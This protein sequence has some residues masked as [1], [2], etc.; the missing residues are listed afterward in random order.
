M[1][2]AAMVIRPAITADI[3]V[4]R[5]LARRIWHA[6]YPAIITMEQIEF[7][8]GWMYSEEEIS[9][10]LSTGT[11]WDVVENDGAACG[12]ISYELQP[13]GRVKL[14]KLYLLPELHGKGMGQR[15]LAHVMGRA[16]SLG[17]REVWMQVNK[18][19][20]RAVAA[21]KKAG[22]HVEK[23]ATFDIGHGFVMDDFL[24]VRAV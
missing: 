11:P 10:Q 5:E 19:N 15:M 12:F 7:M 20:H 9:R 21:Y 13:D 23:E 6:Y 17:G 2:D 24:M 16:R 4:L 22:F 8:L 1:S 18:Q 3:P 14:H